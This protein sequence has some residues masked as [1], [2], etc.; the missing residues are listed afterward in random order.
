M[1]LHP[2][3]KHTA[4]LVTNLRDVTRLKDIHARIS[5]KGPGRKHDVEVLHKSAIVLLVACWEAFV[6]DLV[7][8][9]LDWMIF[10]AKDHQVFPHVVLERIGSTHSGI[11]AWK[12]A[13]NGWKQALRDN[14]K[15]IL[16]RTTG[17]LNTPKSE[18]VN[19]LFEK[20]IGLK[21]ISRFW[22]WQ[23]RPAA[24]SAQALDDLIAMR[25]AIAHRVS[26]AEHVR[27]KDVSEAEYL[28]CQLA[29][30]SHNA[31]CDYLEATFDRR[32]WRLVKYGQPPN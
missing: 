10:Q 28:V 3:N 5:G 1:A 20:T 27:L 2:S 12:L 8:A 19:I 4:Q 32:P 29:A 14:L 11:H 21:N 25:G 26:G 15:E 7:A 18:Q 30:T 9:T 24:K 17:T 23:G 31:V 13:G 22:H 16:A 6:E